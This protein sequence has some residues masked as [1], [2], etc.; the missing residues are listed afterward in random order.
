MPGHKDHEKYL[1]VSIPS[2]H[3]VEICSSFRSRCRFRPGEGSRWR[4]SIWEGIT[5][6]QAAACG[7]EKDSKRALSGKETLSSNTHKS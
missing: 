6:S 4:L 5:E 7:E 1:A 2:H 3:W